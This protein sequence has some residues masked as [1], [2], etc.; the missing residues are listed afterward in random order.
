M[1]SNPIQGTDKWVDD[2]VVFSHYYNTKQ[3]HLLSTRAQFPLKWPS[4]KSVS[5]FSSLACL[6]APLE[7]YQLSV[8]GSR[9]R[10]RKFVSVYNHQGKFGE[11]GSRDASEVLVMES[12]YIGQVLQH[13][14]M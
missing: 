12:T 7:I 13:E 4:D 5:A 1:G 6:V 8:R 11:L 2:C 10:E 3:L 14:N 9:E